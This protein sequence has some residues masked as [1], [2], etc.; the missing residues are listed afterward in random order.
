VQRLC[1]EIAPDG[2]SA[3]AVVARGPAAAQ[4]VLA[5]ALREA[6]VLHGVDAAAAGRLSHDLAR[7]DFEGRVVVA[8]GTPP[9]RSLDGVI[10]LDAAAAAVA[11]V[12]APD[13]SIDYHERH[14]LHAATAGQLL[15]RHTPPRRGANGIDVRGRACAADEPR[16]TT[17]KLGPG[18]REAAGGDIVAERDGVLAFLA[19]KSLDVV[20][21]WE[22]DGNVDLESGNLRTAG[23][24]TIRG[25]VCEGF[26]AAAEHDLVVTGAVLGEAVAAGSLVVAAGVLGQTAV[27]TAGGDL[28]FRHATNADLTA[29]GTVRIGDQAAHSTIRGGVIEAVHGRGH[30][31]GGELRARTRIVCR[32]AGMP[33]GVP[34]LLA[35]GDVSECEP[36]RARL[37]ARAFAAERRL[38]KQV[39]TDEHRDGKRAREADRSGNAARQERLQMLMRQREL[40]RG[41]SIQVLGTIHPAVVV[42]FGDVRQTVETPLSNATFRWDPDQG[43]IVTEQEP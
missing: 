37:D 16:D 40:L 28:S 10:E 15:A 33:I 22:H 31:H 39:R 17:V 8:H 5:G 32:E 14:R 1:I 35:V 12:V 6:G 23:S 42:Q 11:G 3:T 21:L 13:G 34:T 29:G 19:G 2:M 7:E 43:A 4:H 20:P 30:V 26:V 27:A 36:A 41:A 24:L 9:G 25:D 38:Q 18:V